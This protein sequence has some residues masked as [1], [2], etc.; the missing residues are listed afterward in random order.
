MLRMLSFLLV[1][2]SVGE[3]TA[4]LQ[5]AGLQRCPTIEDP[6]ARLACYDAAMP[7][8]FPRAHSPVGPN[9]AATN[10]GAASTAVSP[11]INS[12][13]RG[14]TFGLTQKR[15]AAEIQAIESTTIPGFRQWGP[16]ERIR[17]EN[18][19][20][21][22]VTDGSSGS[23]REVPAKVTIKKGMFGA[24]FLVFHESNWSPKVERVE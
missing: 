24:Y 18:G 13:P 15:D 23:L 20:V 14:S 8:V 19:Q 22:K 12:K 7:P 16:N 10:L 1:S 5:A 17:L 3:A 11:A 9:A 2:V 21:W 4:Q 6:A